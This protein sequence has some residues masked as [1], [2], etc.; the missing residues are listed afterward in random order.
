MRVLEVGVLRGLYRCVAFCLFPCTPILVRTT[1]IRVVDGTFISIASTQK[2]FAALHADGTIAA[3]GQSNAGGTG[4]PTGGGF[5]APWW[6]GGRCRPSSQKVV[7][8]GWM[9]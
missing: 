2:A 1:R 6:V 9:V 3:W 7:L 5:S 4:A 8:G